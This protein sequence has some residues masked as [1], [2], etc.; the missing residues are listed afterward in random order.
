MKNKN[1]IVKAEKLARGLGW[2]S[3]GVGLVELLKTDALARTLGME[4]RTRVLRAYGL[5][6][7]GAGI[8]LLTGVPSLSFWMLARIGG[9]VLDIAALKLALAPK[10]RKRRNAAVALGITAAIT[11]LD[12]VC[13]KQLSD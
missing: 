2:F 9:D 10:N 6:E 13:T 7:I 8:G 3:I 4:H 11:A 5:R 12:V 1:K